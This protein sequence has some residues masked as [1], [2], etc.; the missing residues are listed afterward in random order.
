MAETGPGG[1]GRTG[2]GHTVLPG[3]TPKGAKSSETSQPKLPIDVRVDKN[4]TDVHLH[5]REAGKEYA[6]TFA[7]VGQLG[8][9]LRGV[10]NLKEIKLEDKEGNS[11]PPTPNEI[12]L[13]TRLRADHPEL[14]NLNLDVPPPAEKVLVT[15]FTEALAP[16]QTKAET[17]KPPSA[18][19]VIAAQK[20]ADVQCKKSADGEPLIDEEDSVQQAELAKQVGKC[21]AI[22][23]QPPQS[24]A[25]R[26]LAEKLREVMAQELYD[27]TDFGGHE[28]T[29]QFLCD[30]ANPR[31]TG[32]LLGMV[33][34]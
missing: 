30:L 15:T 27:I 3:D 20:L 34:A 23:D 26:D 9:W 5:T 19:D 25:S 14:R 24:Q 21:L 29:A 28:I 31:L 12:Q 18:N 33:L 1:V 17:H 13:L 32:Q 6:F 22:L 4:G 16:K 2:T 11:R 7:S 10:V 8:R